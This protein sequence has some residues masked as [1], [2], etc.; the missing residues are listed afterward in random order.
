MT[1]DKQNME[2]AYGARKATVNF[3]IE[4]KTWT[5]KGKIRI[6]KIVLKKSFTGTKTNIN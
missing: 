5:E 4:N 3:S 6:E 2:E 1:Q